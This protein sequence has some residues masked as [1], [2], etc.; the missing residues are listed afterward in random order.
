MNSVSA[1]PN[2]FSNTTNI[3][4]NLSEGKAINVNVFDALG[5]VVFTKK[6]NG[7]VGENT[8]VFDGTSLTAGVYY[9]TVTAG[10]EKVTKKMVI[11]K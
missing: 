11:Q 5:K 1:Y 3:V 2:P 10:Y 8:I 9:Y 6:T 4:V 7:N